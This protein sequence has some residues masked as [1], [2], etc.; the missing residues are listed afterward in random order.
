MNL[1]ARHLYRDY[2]DGGGMRAVGTASRNFSPMFRLAWIAQKAGGHG[3]N[4]V[5]SAGCARL[6][7]GGPLLHILSWLV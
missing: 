6:I 1:G 5:A 4:I 3:P 7:E 2:G